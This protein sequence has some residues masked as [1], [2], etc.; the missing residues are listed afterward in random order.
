VAT[1]GFAQIDEALLPEGG[2]FI[3]RP[4]SKDQI[5]GTICD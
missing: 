5:T 1:S 2:R 3:A 4:Y